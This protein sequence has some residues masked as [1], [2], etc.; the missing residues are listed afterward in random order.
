MVFYAVCPSPLVE[1][2][3]TPRTKFVAVLLVVALVFTV[4]VVALR[5]PEQQEQYGPNII[6]G[7]VVFPGQTTLPAETIAFCKANGW[8]V[9]LSLPSYDAVSTFANPAKATWYAGVIQ[10]ITNQGIPVWLEIEVPIYYASTVSANTTPAQYQ[11]MYGQGLAIYEKLG[12]LFKGYSFEGGYDNA[13][14][15]LKEHSQKKLLSHWLPYY[16]QEYNTGVPNYT[17]TNAP[18]WGTHNMTWRVNQFDEIVWETYQVDWVQ[19]AVH[20]KNWLDTVAP[21]KPFGVLTGWEADGGYWWNPDTHSYSLGSNQTELTAA[22]Q[23]SLMTTW[24]TW[25]KA[26]IGP[27]DLIVCDPGGQSA[28]VPCTYLDSLNLINGTPT[29]TPT[30]T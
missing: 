14:I 16:Y 15:W 2:R 13:I 25:L 18:E 1:S 19:S 11:A 21:S 12:P 30:A 28:T 17:P 3:I 6:F 4:L 7:Q 10:N 24:L 20:F 22:E 27:F 5:T 8:G 23:Q 9:E 26:Q 29:P